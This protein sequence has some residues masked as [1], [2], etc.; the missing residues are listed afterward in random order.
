MNKKY[1]L[2]PFFSICIIILLSFYISAEE[3]QSTNLENIIEGLPVSTETNVNLQENDS[4]INEEAEINL[5]EIEEN[6]TTGTENYPSHSVEINNSD[7]KILSTN[8]SSYEVI[9]KAENE[10]NDTIQN[11][12]SYQS[13]G[14]SSSGSGQEIYYVNLENISIEKISSEEKR[15]NICSLQS[16]ENR[17]EIKNCENVDILNIEL[18]ET[19][20]DEFEKEVIVSSTEHINQIVT[21]NTTLT[22]ESKK[23][24]IHIYWKNENNLEITSIEEFSVKYY[25]EN[26]NGLIDIVSWDIPHLSEQIFD[27]VVEITTTDTGESIELSVIAETE[28]NPINFSV[29]VNYDYLTNVNC[30]LEIN[31]SSNRIFLKY[32]NILP[33]GKQNLSALNLENGAYNWEII[34]W[35][36]TTPSISDNVIGNFEVNEEFDISLNEGKVYLLDLTNNSIRNPE[37]IT[38]SSKNLSNFSIKLIRNGQIIPVKNCSNSCTIALNE[39]LLNSY[40]FYNLSV[41]FNEPSP[42]TLMITNFTVASV[43]LIL[44]DTSIE[45][46]D[47]VKINVLIN[48]P[49][50]K[51]SP[52]YLEYGDGTSDFNLT[53]MIQFNKEIAKKYLQKGQYTLN[54]SVSIAELGTYQVKKIVTVT[55]PTEDDTDNDKPSISNINPEDGKIIYIPEVNFSYKVTDNS[56]AGIKNCSFKLYNA[57]KKTVGVSKGTLVASNDTIKSLLPGSY[58]TK[59]IKVSLIKFDDGL[60]WWDVECFDN[61]LNKQSD[62]GNIFEIRTNGTSAKSDSTYPE[63]LT[64]IDNL[65]DQAD[66]FLTT[67]FNLEEQEVLEDLNILNDTKYYKKRLLDIESFFEENYKYVSSEI[68]KEKKIEEYTK[69]LENIEN[70]IPQDITIEDNYE[71]VKNSLDADFEGII[72]N[73]LDSTNVQLSSSSIRK[74]VKINKEIQN[75]ISVSTIVKNVKIEYA[76]GT[77]EM[78]FV[79][80]KITLNDDTYTKI[81]EIIPTELSED[82]NIVFITE[83]NEMIDE[84]TIFELDYDELNNEEIVYYI[85]SF[86]K[87]KNFEGTET[88]LFEDNLNKFESNGFTGFSILSPSSSGFAIYFILAILL[89]IVIIFILLPVLKKIKM[90]SWEK[91]PNIRRVKELIKDIQILLKDREI[92]EAKEKYYKIKEIYPVLPNNTKSYFYNKMKEISVKIDRADILG[93]VKEFQE[94]KKRWNKEEYMRLYQDIKK[95]Y[96]RLP[97]KDQKRVHAILYE[98]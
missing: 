31:K 61:N 79:K 44:N 12:T 68:L 74:L 84:G 86:V 16:S 33:A 17:I 71:Y 93:L 97:A 98:Y 75:E 89:L 58:S 72:K 92:E 43:N 20:K 1:P 65:K 30:S 10:S 80:K 13:E 67:D 64:K 70:R 73:Y 40:G 76:N 29:N 22:T 7:E 87:L 85:D 47:R 26:N 36:K 90:L 49:I 83:E 37:L 55:E 4:Q 78:A 6:Q 91:E 82:E 51:I 9:T 8:I 95:L 32:F 57:I 69:E 77:Q 42:K 14:S 24:D 5:E 28:I 19:E 34:C 3:N 2:K 54:L 25:D 21:I 60:Y 52:V 50:K 15:E 48:S 62:L 56:G 18:E 38:I 81:L 11:R 39:T 23:E 45:E 96:K 88:L 27:V 53:E 41:E 59:T 35:D 46:G 66:V 63:E 94:T